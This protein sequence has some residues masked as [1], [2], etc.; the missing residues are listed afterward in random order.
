MNHSLKQAQCCLRCPL[1]TD[2]DSE[3][4]EQQEVSHRVTCSASTLTPADTHIQEHCNIH[5]C[6]ERPISGIGINR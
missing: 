4:S 5:I 6:P 3:G 1:H 2:V